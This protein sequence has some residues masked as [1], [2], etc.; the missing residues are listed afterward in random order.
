MVSYKSLSQK[1]NCIE[2]KVSKI[3]NG[4]LLTII[5]REDKGLQELNFIGTV[6]AATTD[7][8]KFP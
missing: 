8:V 4:S 2:N 6:R 1:T 7:A 5:L 3:L